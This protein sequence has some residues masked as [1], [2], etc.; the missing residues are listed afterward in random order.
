MSLV[1][2]CLSLDKIP[3]PLEIF[4]LTSC[5]C[6]F[7]RLLVCS[8]VTV[9][10]FAYSFVCSFACSFARLLVCSFDLL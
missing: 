5:A 8:F 6:S 2:K 7:V 1:T 10:S 9:C 4:L 3:I